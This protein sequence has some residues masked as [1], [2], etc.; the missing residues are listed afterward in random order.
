[1]NISGRLL[2]YANCAASAVSPDYRWKRFVLLLLLF[3]LARGIVLLCIL[4]PFEGWDEYQHVAY[5]QHL[6]EYGEPP[7]LRRS[8]VSRDL[9]EALIAFPQ[10]PDMARQLQETGALDYDAFYQRPQPP[11][12][13]PSHSEIPLYQAQHGMLYYKLV[14]PVFSAVG[15][16][17]R[18]VVSV[19]SLR[20]INL[21]FIVVSL[22]LCI[23]L[24]GDIIGHNRHAALISFIVCCQPL[25]LINGCRIAN[26]ALAV[27][28]ATWVI[29]WT[30]KPGLQNRLIH[31][32]LA[33]FAFGAGVWAKTTVLALAP[34]IVICLGL[35]VYQKRIAV[36]KALMTACIFIVAAAA[37][38]FP[39]FMFGIRQY[40]MLAPMQE[41]L[42][43]RDKGIGFSEMS[44]MCLDMNIPLRIVK[45]W[46]RDSLWIGGWSFLKVK[47]VHNLLFLVLIAGL[48]GW[49][50]QIFRKPGRF[51]PLFDYDALNFKCI[52]LIACLSAGL[53]WHMVVL[54][55]AWFPNTASTNPWY[56]A[57]A[58]PFG[59]VFVYNGAKRWNEKIAAGLGGSIAIIYLGTEFYGMVFKM[60]PFYSGGGAGIF[61]MEKISRFHPAWMGF[62]TFIVS[63]VLGFIVLLTIGMVFARFAVIKTDGES[64]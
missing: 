19:Y 50:F 58:F 43:I 61:A 57:M 60:I 23:W 53:A 44:A 30:L 54:R 46:L 33:G 5:V 45:L 8:T 39:Q 49:V 16:I 9:L 22:A 1:M 27:L 18:L 4:P 28:S 52:V 10:P 20:V 25:Y 32:I 3:V 11:E 37:V 48:S 29:A 7:V 24:F 12:Y 6:I 35:S 63:A 47:F 14:R 62:S 15:G 21:F 31:T 64:H 2:K 36:H 38:S 55:A 56:V 59:L 17:E 40:G 42:I 34:Y 51:Q 41:S 13:N 26:D